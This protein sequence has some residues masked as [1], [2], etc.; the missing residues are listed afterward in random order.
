[1]FHVQTKYEER[2]YKKN[3]RKKKKADTK[4]EKCKE[5]YMPKMQRNAIPYLL[6]V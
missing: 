3:T 1:M 5:K 6:T 4:T 2:K